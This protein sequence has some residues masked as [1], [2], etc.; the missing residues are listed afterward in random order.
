MEVSRREAAGL[1]GRVFGE[2]VVREPMSSG[3]FGM[4]F[5]AEQPAL[6][7]Q[8]VIKVLHRRLLGSETV[9][10]RFLR[11]ARLA[12]LL[13]HPYAAHTYA[14][15]AEPDGILW[16]AMELV[17]GT[18][19]DR[20]LETHGPIAL[21]RFLPL[22]ERIC[23]VVQTAHERGIVHRDLKP[24]NVM[25][26]SR[27][28][29]LLPKLLDFGIAKL[30]V[31]AEPGAPLAGLPVPVGPVGDHEQAGS[32]ADTAPAAETPTTSS[33]AAARTDPGASA[34]LT[35][36]GATMGSPLYM[37]P[38]QWSNAAEVDART[39]L[40]ALGVLCYEALTGTAPFRGA[41]SIDIAIAHARQAPPPLGGSLPG[42]LDPVIAR[43]LAKD[44]ADRYPSALEFFAAFRTASGLA[45]DSVSLPRLDE[46]VRAIATASAPRP[47]AVAIETLDVAR[48][49]H[50]ARDA[51]WQVVRAAVRLV[52]VAALA[53][54]AHVRPSARLTDPGTESALRRLRERALSDA[55]WL[56]LAR[57]LVAPFAELREAHPIPELVEFLLARSPLDELV[58]LRAEAEEAGG[59]GSEDRVHGLLARALPLLERLIQQAS[60][61]RDYRLVVPLGDGGRASD[62]S[63]AR[64]EPF[65]TRIASAPALAPG[66]P[67]L[68]DPG[69]AAVVALWPFVQVAEPSPGAPPALFFLEGKGRRGARLVSLTDGFE[70]EDEELWESLGGLLA[71]ADDRLDTGEEAHPFP[72][73]AAFTAADAAVFFGRERET[74]AAVNRLRVTPLLAIVGPSGAGKSS[75]VQAGILPSLSPDWLAITLRPGPAPSVSLR[76]RLVAA[77]VDVRALSGEIAQNPGALGGALRTFAAARRQSVVL[78]VDQL[79]ELYTLCDDQAE[80]ERFSQA[81]VHAARS[82]DD[83]VRVIVTMRDDFLLRIEA[84]EA[85]RSRL[86]RA[87]QLLA[88]PAATELRRILT[89]P[90]RRA[91]YEFDDPSLPDTMI[92]EVAGAPGALALLAFT[93]SKLW[94]LRDRRFRQ[95]GHKA[96]RSLG[97]V[98]GALAQHAESTLQSMHAEEQR[99][100][101][102]VFRRAV[103]DEGTRAVL[104]RAEL[105]EVLGGGGAAGVVLEKLVAARLLVTSEAE[106]GEGERVEV[107]HEALLEAWPRLVGW[108][109]EDAEG[110]RLRDQLAAAAR[111]WDERGRPSGL[112]W[113]GDALAEYRLWRPRYPGRL[114]H[115]EEEF[116]AA[117]QADEARGRRMRRGLAIAAFVVL[118][119]VAALLLVQKTRVER[120][121]A[122]AEANERKVQAS[123]A[124]LEEVVRDQYES[125][126]RRLLLADDPLQALAYLNKA[127]GHGARGTAHDLEVAWAVSLTGGELSAVAHD[128]MVARA[129]FS[130]DDRL[131]A[132]V[133]YDQRARLWDAASGAALAELV[134]A[135]PVIRV[136]WSPDGRFIATGSESGELSLW[137]VPGGERR[138]LAVAGA[139]VQALA[140]SPDGARLVALT[141]DD[142]VRLWSVADGTLVRE[143]RAPAVAPAEPSGSLVAYAPD[144]ARIAAGDSAGAVQLFEVASGR[145][146]L[147]VRHRARVASV[148]FSPDGGQ[149]VSASR[150]GTA[151]IS[152][153]ARPGEPR[154]LRHDDAVRSAL[155]SPDGRRLV[156]ASYDGSAAVWDGATG[157][158]LLKLAGHEGRVSQAVWSPDGAAIA[159]ASEDG[160]AILWE[161]ASGR[162]LA[163]RYGHRASV[164]DVSFT[165]SGRRLVTASLDGTAVVSTA[166]AAVRTTALAGHSA[167]VLSVAF[168]P[169]GSRA[170]TASADA[171]A[172]IW[173][174]TS[175]RQLVSLPHQG[176]VVGARFSPDGSRLAT[177][178]DSGLVRVWDV[179]SGA[180]VADLAGHQGQVSAID[181]DAR[182]E[183]LVSAG[184]D[185]TVRIWSLAERRQLASFRPAGGAAV[186]WAAFVSGG[187]AVVAGGFDFGPRVLDAASGRVIAS[188]EE[189]G[190]GWRGA[191]DRTGTRVVAS[192][193]NRSVRIWNLERGT[194]ELELRGHRSEV[195]EV[196]WSADGQLIVTAS[197]DGTARIWDAAAGAALVVLDHQGQLVQ[198][199]AFSPDGSRVLVGQGD[200]WAAIWQLPR[201]PAGLADILRCRVPYDLEAPTLTPRPVDRRAC[202]ALPVH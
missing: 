163:R 195:N 184:Q 147:L 157:G 112:L 57:E 6:A 61:L 37:A 123:A 115:S 135:G 60:F 59:A 159:T 160:T 49:A 10:Q 98:G 40:Y 188:L 138:Q 201:P 180:P 200:G 170:A 53:G 140:F 156:T 101:R 26:L 50:Q 153:I 94:E 74:E 118:A 13:D 80:R 88:P 16:I 3:G 18:P 145:S 73:L 63:G 20:M 171:T 187:T 179:D 77:G 176:G 124:R 168:S 132:T 90:V 158:R 97:G 105:E 193:L 128:G 107:I 93:A 143:L 29:R 87:L 44:P 65:E 174:P 85:W 161:A 17:R 7:R 34:R 45:I 122:R 30:D 27:A 66:R 54:H 199:A 82:P 47:L 190:L 182:G 4:V 130:P 2:F 76:S 133:G 69:G 72:G 150:D 181:W 111:Q 178:G 151:A 68:T 36:V 126:A 141:T 5:R 162:R 127:A 102:E 81:L 96:Y 25:V 48:N 22:L 46:R 175:G 1:V 131:L 89:E 42:A 33:A 117:S 55:G 12:S 109:R 32:L 154:L 21:E 100:V 198:A 139:A 192:T 8:A 134:H 103:T 110:A 129:R 67:L 196:D 14:F 104:R 186:H 91:G 194:A 167:E 58:A 169:D 191:V 86:G 15:G 125:Q 38:E 41:S 155:F 142:A 144:G 177:G 172:R 106:G 52:G 11:E 165:H 92:A 119:A 149:V 164:V 114:T 113:R 19:L 95:I 120:Q 64:R 121:R 185:G 166:E 146:R 116:A 56:E 183:R 148:A 99:L 136:E 39:D 23:E 43:A 173:D 31:D 202:T 24:A 108:R 83:P 78:V 197:L 35:H 28:G 189:R 9:V 71:G 137:Q 79:E 70:H 152:T 62:W 51:L 75:F 84:L